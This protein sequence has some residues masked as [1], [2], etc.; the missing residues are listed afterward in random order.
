MTRTR[1]YH[2][3]R[4]CN[5]AEVERKH[6]RTLIG[7]RES[8]LPALWLQIAK[9]K[10]WITIE[11]WQPAAPAVQISSVVPEC[12]CWTG[13]RCLMSRTQT[14]LWSVAIILLSGRWWRLSLLPRLIDQP[15]SSQFHI[16]T[17][18]NLHNPASPDGIAEDAYRS[19]SS[20]GG[21]SRR[22]KEGGS[23]ATPDCWQPWQPGTVLCVR[24]TRHFPSCR[25]VCVFPGPIRE[26]RAHNMIPWW[27]NREEAE[28]RRSILTSV[29]TLMILLCSRVQ[30]EKTSLRVRS[31]TY[32]HSLDGDTP[33]LMCLLLPDGSEPAFY[34]T[35][36][37]IYTTD[38]LRSGFL[39]QT[40]ILLLFLLR[41]LARLLTVA[42]LLM[43]A[44][45]Q[46]C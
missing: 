28:Q 46:Q 32:I 16:N 15:Q 8:S 3:R 37:F 5:R 2:R 6:C 25:A 30:T 9:Y 35:C 26:R 18:V 13:R 43:L 24:P 20:C 14:K 29:C 40:G 19:I 31:E 42:K 7:Q 36:W 23:P 38:S 10:I 45:Q 11:K 21:G 34:K 17:A 27:L 4:G 39:D 12:P 33:V 22:N 1:W 44:L 41:I